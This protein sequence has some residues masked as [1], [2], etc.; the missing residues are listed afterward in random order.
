[1]KTIFLDN[2]RQEMTEFLS[3]PDVLKPLTKT[4][5]D[6]IDLES[7]SREELI[8]RVKSL[9]THVQQ[10]RN[11]IAKMD[12]SSLPSARVKQKERKFDFNRFKRRHILLQVTTNQSQSIINEILS[13]H[14]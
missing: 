8:S 6:N 2:I 3:N 4:R 10:L 9:E 5:R 1:M 12:N 7:L 11:V 13:N 14:I